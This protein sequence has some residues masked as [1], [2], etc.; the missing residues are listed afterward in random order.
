M[1]LF[2]VAYVSTFFQFRLLDQ[3]SI[4]DFNLA[5]PWIFILILQTKENDIMFNVLKKFVIINPQ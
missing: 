5:D 4:G 1:S 2:A 3:L